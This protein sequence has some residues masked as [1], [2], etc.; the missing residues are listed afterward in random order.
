MVG[1]FNRKIVINILL[2]I[3]FF[4]LIPINLAWAANASVI[5]T[6]DHNYDGTY[7][8][9]LD[10]ENPLKFGICR[11]PE[12]N[13]LKLKVFELGTGRMIHNSDFKTGY[14]SPRPDETKKCGE[15][16]QSDIYGPKIEGVTYKPS[17]PGTW[18]IKA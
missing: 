2:S 3:L 9:L 6:I 18:S 15:S 1:S 17:Q 4:L 11:N 14:Q 16:G 12:S 5:V 10:R 8:L 13:K 7:Y